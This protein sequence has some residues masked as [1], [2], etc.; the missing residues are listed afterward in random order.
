MTYCRSGVNVGVSND[1]PGGEYFPDP[2]TDASTK[3]CPSEITHYSSR[4]SSLKSSKKSQNSSLG[5]TRSPRKYLKGFSRSNQ[6]LKNSRNLHPKNYTENHGRHQIK[7]N[8]SSTRPLQKKLCNTSPLTA[9]VTVRSSP[10]R[11]VVSPDKL[12]AIINEPPMSDPGARECP[13]RRCTLHTQG[14]EQGASRALVAASDLAISCPF[15]RIGLSQ[16]SHWPQS[17][18]S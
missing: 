10:C 3:T 17:S 15:P 18:C 5:E 6:V 16:R 2:P 7:K 14:C 4:P 1:G 9:K 13:R 11:P 12:F 8:E